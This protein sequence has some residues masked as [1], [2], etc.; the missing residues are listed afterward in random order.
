MQESQGMLS[1]HLAGYAR[2]AFAKAITKLSP[3]E[4]WPGPRV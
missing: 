2:E 1:E 3:I 4:A